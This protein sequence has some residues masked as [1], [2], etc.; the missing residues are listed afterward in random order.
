MTW[1]WRVNQKS[2]LP[3]SVDSN[4]TFTT[5][6]CRI[7]SISK[8]YCV[9]LSL[10]NKTLCKKLLSFHNDFSLIPLGKSV[11]GRRATNRCNKFK[12]LKFWECPLFEISK[13]AFKVQQ[14]QKSHNEGILCFWNS[15]I[16]MY[17]CS[18]MLHINVLVT[19]TCK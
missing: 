14:H 19:F 18:Q 1:I 9:K 13:Y 10:I 2:L 8:D 12:L 15:T 6:Q 7:T 17:S 16:D 3:K 11:N 4:F 5:S